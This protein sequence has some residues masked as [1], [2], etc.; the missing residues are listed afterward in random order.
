MS[1]FDDKRYPER[2]TVPLAADVAADLRALAKT[3]GTTAAAVVR[4]AV[5]RGLGPL[6]EALRKERQRRRSNSGTAAGSKPAA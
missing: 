4:E 1:I 5:S 2:I 3:H 6:K